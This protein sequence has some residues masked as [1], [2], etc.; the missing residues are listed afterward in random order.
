MKSGGLVKHALG[1][2][3]IAEGTMRVSVCAW[4]QTWTDFNVFA[5]IVFTLAC[6]LYTMASIVYFA[7]SFLKN[8]CYALF[9]IMVKEKKTGQKRRWG[10]DDFGHPLH[11]LEVLFAIIYE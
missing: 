11:A 2:D 7:M 10:D 4:S 6:I 5:M 9:A 3:D 1:S 8:K